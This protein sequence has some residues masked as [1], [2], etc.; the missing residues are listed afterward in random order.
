VW[1]QLG[2]NSPNKHREAGGGGHTQ[3]TAEERL[4]TFAK[5]PNLGIGLGHEASFLSI[6]KKARS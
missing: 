3:L 2:E 4:K 6:L 1:C 5:N